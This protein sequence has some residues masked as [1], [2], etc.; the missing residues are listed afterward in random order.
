MTK[1]VLGLV[2]LTSLSGNPSAKDPIDDPRPL[3]LRI[4]PNVCLAPCEI[5]FHIWIR[6]ES[7]GQEVTLIVDDGLLLTSSSWP[8][9]GRLHTVGR[10]KGIPAGDYTVVVLHAGKLAEQALKVSG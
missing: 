10:I 9:D 8:H 3:V 7:Q 2:F 4:I 5:D 6:T 1:I